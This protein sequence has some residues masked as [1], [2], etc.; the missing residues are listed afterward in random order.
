MSP[1][2]IDSRHRTAAVALVLMGTCATHCGG[3]ATQDSPALSPADAA[4]SDAADAAAS[5]AADAADATLPCATPIEIGSQADVPS[6]DSVEW[7]WSCGYSSAGAPITPDLVA[8]AELVLDAYAIPVPAG[9]TSCA[10]KVGFKM[11]EPIAGVTT[12]TPALNVAD[13]YLRASAG[14]SFRLRPVRVCNHP[15]FPDPLLSVLVVPSCKQPCASGAARCDGDQVCYGLGKPFCRSCEGKDE[16]SCA[17]RTPTG[18]LP[19]NAECSYLMTDV[20][21]YGV[22][23]GGTCVV[24]Q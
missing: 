12:D 24:S 8:T 5:D 21:M 1:T 10:D 17:C 14:A 9:C 16:P 6:F 4:T 3:K 15:M 23:Q 20:M 13:R 7:G 11:T 18:V 22:C 2:M 19:D